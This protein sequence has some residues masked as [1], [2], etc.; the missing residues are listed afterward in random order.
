MPRKKT[1]SVFESRGRWYALVRVNGKRH[2]APMPWC[3]NEDDARARAGVMAEHANALSGS[4]Q[5]ELAPKLLDTLAAAVTADEL[6]LARGLIERVATG[7]LGKPSV[8]A[9]GSSFADVANAWTS[10][11]LARDYP[12]SV[13][14][15]SS[16]A[17]DAQRLR[18]YILPH[19][20]RIPMT[21]LHAND[22]SEVLKKL[23]EH[24]SPA[25]RRQVGQIMH[26][27]AELAVDPLGLIAVN[28]VRKAPK[29]KRS[30]QRPQEM[31]TTTELDR[32][33]ACV[34]VPLEVRVFVGF[35]AHEG[36]REDE[37]DRLTWADVNENGLVRCHENKTDDPRAWAMGED[38]ARVMRRWFELKGKP[39]RDSLVFTR[40]DGEPLALLTK[41][42]RRWLR[43]AGI[44]RAD[45]HEGTKTTD[46]TAFHALRALFVSNALANGKSE[47]WVM[48]RTGHTT[49]QQVQGY[50]RRAR[51]F[52]EAK[53]PALADF[54]QV[55]VWVGFVKPMVKRSDE[56]EQRESENQGETQGFRCVES[57]H[58]SRIQSPS[59]DG[60]EATSRE[61]VG[62]TSTTS[63]D[64]NQRADQSS[65][66][67]DHSGSGLR[68][69]ANDY[70][71]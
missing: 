53:L 15:K 68:S 66:M 19:V 60:V 20:G 14:P 22:C 11:Q 1:G 16:A 33:L 34:D 61:E 25:T 67:V 4:E 10:G 7:K 55:L 71:R 8:S 30:Q 54:D 29:V 39:S 57:N 3:T 43:V 35:L 47:A 45:L 12:D 41:T 24:L 50:N 63:N 59:F 49:S 37:A 42:Y 31:L 65:P 64:Q 6:I 32:F 58:G 46:V 62:V 5:Y 2:C 21:R 48:L 51:S 38:T 44:D 9:P 27:V 52:E 69:A 40:D 56:T 23:P 28:P 70:W 13:D 18:D 17:L 36:M 26:R